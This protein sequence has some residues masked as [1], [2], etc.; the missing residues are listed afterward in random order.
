MALYQHDIS[1]VAD[2]GVPVSRGWKHFRVEFLGERP[3]GNTPGENN[4]CFNLICQTEP[5]VG[6]VVFTPL[7]LQAH[8]LMGLKALYKAC[9]YTPG[10]EGHDPTTIDGAECYGKVDWDD[11]DPTTK[12]SKPMPATQTEVMAEHQIRAKIAP[13]NYR[14]M[15]EGVP[16]R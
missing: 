2:M 1:A 8:A 14:S 4:L 6:R 15:R 9:G 3:S 5:E 7:S 12:K 13:W 16:A 10:P 11:Y